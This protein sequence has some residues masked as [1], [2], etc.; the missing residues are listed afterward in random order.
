MSEHICRNCR[1]WDE[2]ALAMY[3]DEFPKKYSEWRG[4]TL[5]HSSNGRPIHK[6]SL[7]VA[8]DGE[9]CHGGLATAPNFG[10]VQWEGKE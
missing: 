9:A 10:C 5:A 2:D 6:N 8:L 4:C 7:A 1:W 3:M